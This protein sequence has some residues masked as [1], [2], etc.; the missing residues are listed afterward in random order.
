MRY[1]TLHSV[2]QGCAVTAYI[3]GGA[4][5]V[6]AWMNRMTSIIG[7]HHR[8]SC[9]CV[10]PA[11]PIAHHTTVVLF[12]ACRWC[13]QAQERWSCLQSTQVI[14]VLS[15]C[16]GMCGLLAGW[17]HMQVQLNMNS[18]T[19]RPTCSQPSEHEDSQQCTQRHHPG[20]QSQ[21]ARS[22]TQSF[23]SLASHL[24]VGSLLGAMGALQPWQGELPLLRWDHKASPASQGTPRPSVYVLRM[25][26]R[27][28]TEMGPPDTSTPCIGVST[29]H[30]SGS[31]KTKRLTLPQH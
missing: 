28:V 25:T 19:T 1:P 7:K 24:F 23:T 30:A 26:V 11:L 13:H 10:V 21:L 27:V 6:A 3:Q 12:G 17:L 8:K 5:R 22:E 16:L 4:L 18:A 29:V 15:L 31:A 9:T 14:P 20:L 2:Q